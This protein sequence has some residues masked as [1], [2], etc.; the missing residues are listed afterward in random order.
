MKNV[1][2]VVVVVAD[3]DVDFDF[4]SVIGAVEM[5][6]VEK[7]GMKEGNIDYPSSHSYLVFAIEME[8]ELEM[9]KEF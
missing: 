6:I 1:A 7:V 8:V 2:V 9:M 4:D 5:Q 3:V